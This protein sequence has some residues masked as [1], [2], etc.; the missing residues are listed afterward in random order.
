MSVDRQV[1]AVL[2]NAANDIAVRSPDAA[3]SVLI[4][5]LGLVGAGHSVRSQLLPEAVR[6]L[7]FAG[8]LPEAR[9]LGRL[10]L[11]GEKDTATKASVEAGLA[12]ALMYTGRADIVVARVRRALAEEGVPD[13]IRASL[14]AVQAHGLLFTSDVGAARYTAD[15]AASL[16]RS[17]GDRAAMMFAILAQSVV[18]RA[19]G[20]LEDSVSAAWES[21]RLGDEGRG[22]ERHRHPKLWAARAAAAVDRFA[23]AESGLESGQ[24]EAEAAGALWSLPLWHCFRSKLRLAEGKLDQAEAQAR[25]GLEGA[26]RLTAHVRNVCMLGVLAQIA[27]HRGN[28]A[29]AREHMHRACWL[30]SQGLNAMEDQVRWE[31]AL[32]YD[33]C[34]DYDGAV[35]KAVQTAEVLPDRL[36]LLTDD[37]SIGPQIVRILVRAGAVLEAERV[38]GA[39]VGLAQANPFVPSL[40]GAAFHAQGLLHS[41]AATLRAAVQAYRVS[42]RK[43]A[44]ASALEDAAKAEYA[45]GR[46]DAASVFG[47]EALSVYNSL[48]A[49]RAAKRAEASLRRVGV[50]HVT[51][52]RDTAG[53][54]A[55]TQAERRVA[56]LVTQG[57]TNHAVAAALS[58]SSHTVDSHLRKVFRK[59]GVGN[60]VALTRLALHEEREKL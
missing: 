26:S 14:L 50:R 38:C 8:R 22:L 53:W 21:V 24:Q 6:L 23:E 48:G 17:C 58:I 3:A 44:A 10:A 41:D 32:V 19:E 7:S 42:P 45:A 29:S 13:E 39:L 36:L 15:A 43:L 51:H 60:R 27:V 35:R 37:P 56:D 46:R 9:L 20:R 55:L 47:Q 40:T 1:L 12:E 11:R 2:R 30:M 59:L 33:G 34:G 28:T 5:T 4:R 52:S 54:G 18:A 31:L 25:M 16:A 57:M 49:A